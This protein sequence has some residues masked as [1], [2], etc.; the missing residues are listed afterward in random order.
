MADRNPLLRQAFEEAAKREIDELPAEN[1]VGN[2]YSVIH[3]KKINKV[4]DDKQSKKKSISFKRVGTFIL[5]AVIIMTLIAIGAS[6]VVR[7]LG[8]E[9]LFSKEWRESIKEGVFNTTDTTDSI[10]FDEE[11]KNSKD[12]FSVVS[13][14]AQRGPHIILDYDDS[15]EYTDVAAEDEGYRFELKSVT[16]ARKKHR[17]ITAGNIS[18]STVVYEWTISESYFAI[19]E[20][21]KC[22]GNVLSDKEKD[23]ITDMKWSYLIMGYSPSLTGLTFRNTV[24]CYDD[25]YRLYYAVEITDMMPFAKRGFGFTFIESEAEAG[26]ET[27]WADEEGN[28]ELK[29]EDEYLGVLLKFSV[30][31]KYADE[32]YVNSYFRERGLSQPEKWFEN[33]YLNAN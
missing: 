25:E 6:G 1:A 32:E 17:I 29:D 15:T 10:A 12:N 9:Y 33:Y 20:I 21:S 28:L 23:V 11:I 5:S 27:L 30:D 19:I 26:K 2:P 24:F 18:D 13:L 4:F 22:D 3:I 14:K 8:K 16:K 31:K 7:I